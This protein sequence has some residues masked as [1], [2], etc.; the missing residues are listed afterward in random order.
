MLTINYTKEFNK[1][2]KTPSKVYVDTYLPPCPPSLSIR[3]RLSFQPNRWIKYT[4]YLI[5]KYWWSVLFLTSNLHRHQLYRIPLKVDKWFYREIKSIQAQGLSDSN[6]NKIKSISHC[7]NNWEILLFTTEQCATIK[8]K[9][10]P[11]LSD[12]INVRKRC[13][14]FTHR[15]RAD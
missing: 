4:E 13:H 3:L 12:T 14:R 5:G 15:R 11:H 7:S 9:M 6:Q 10:H 2:T 1:K 8:P